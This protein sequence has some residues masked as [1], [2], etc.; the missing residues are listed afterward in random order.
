MFIGVHVRRGGL[1]FLFFVPQIAATAFRVI[2][3]ML[4]DVV[5]EINPVPDVPQVVVMSG[6]YLR[7]S[8]IF[9]QTKYRGESP[10]GKLVHTTLTELRRDL[11]YLV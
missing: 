10:I 8:L 11:F 2:E 6:N 5:A 9:D 3:N 4:N 7:S 1:A